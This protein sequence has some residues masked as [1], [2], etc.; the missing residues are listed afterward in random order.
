MNKAATVTL[1]TMASMVISAISAK[2]RATIDA[3]APVGY[4]DESGFH[5][6]TPD[7]KD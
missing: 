1:L 3:Q 7:F 4:E 6:G 5:F 2:V